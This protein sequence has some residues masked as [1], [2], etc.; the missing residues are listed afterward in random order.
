M[1]IC[2]VKVCPLPVKARELCQGHYFRLLRHGDPGESPI[3]DRRPARCSVDGCT[4]R[5]VQGSSGLCLKHHRRAEKGGSV[6]YVGANT[7]PTNGSWKGNEVGYNAAHD[8]VRRA[9]GAAS[10]QRCACGRQARHWAYDHQ[11]PAELVDP[12]GYR[13]SGDPGH[14]LPQCVPC[15]KRGDLDRLTYTRH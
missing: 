4:G 1:R 12:R 10:K 15:H 13:Y 14:Y 9:R 5:W 11:D 7:G 2:R 8:R 6:D 3:S